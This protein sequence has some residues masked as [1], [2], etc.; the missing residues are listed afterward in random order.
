MTRRLSSATLTLALC[1]CA[2]A[3]SQ[4]SAD[5]QQNSPLANV[6]GAAQVQPQ[7]AARAD[8]QW[9][10][11]WLAL[12]PQGTPPQ[13]Y[14]VYL[15]RLGSDGK[16]QFAHQGIQVANLGVGW[17]E[18]YGLA[19]DSQ[20]NAVLT[21]QDDRYNPPQ[22]AI[23][24][25]KVDS[26][27]NLLWNSLTAHTGHAPHVSILP[28]GQSFIGWSAD[29]ENTV[30]LRKLDALG[31]PVWR[32]RTGAPL[33][34]ILTEPNFT[35]A[36]ADLQTTADGSVIVSFVRSRGFSGARHLYANKISPTG[37][38]LWG[39][40]HVKVFDG[41]SL[42]QGNLPRFVTDGNGGA[43]FA[44]YSVDPQ[45]QVS[46][47]H[48]LANGQLAFPPNGVPVSTDQQ[49]ARVSPAV[50]YQP[51]TGETTLLW[52]ELDNAMAQH[53]RGLYAQR[54]N[55]SG[56]RLWGDS[57]RPI[58]PIDLHS[59]TDIQSVASADG[60][61][62]FWVE[63]VPGRTDSIQGIKLGATGEPLCPQF[64]VSTRAAS[65]SRLAAAS[66]PSGQVLL[67]WEEQGQ[68]QGSDIYTQS[69]RADCKLGGQ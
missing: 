16:E 34:F 44:W 20:G 53:R 8:G 12:H 62:A 24:A 3:W 50:S 40:A 14:D 33:D 22:R 43:V 68:N 42:Q 31:Q 5:P 66:T 6:A 28:D 65:K 64:A 17:T 41:G 2:N 63:S 35:Y 58:R 19:T 47:Q 36:L 10:I 61:L 57:G 29:T 39:P 7:I 11:S 23:S 56:T 26:A 9:W 60:T 30:R 37:Q 54:I 46:A 27:G 32:D 55:A 25:T 48:V 4:W 38:L 52:T 1:L 69:V 15:Q 51:A 21:F 59:I 18:D 13:G 45:L 49:Q 67:V